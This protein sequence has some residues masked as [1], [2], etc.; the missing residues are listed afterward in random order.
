[1]RAASDAS[2]CA[3]MVRRMHGLTDPEMDALRSPLRH[4]AMNSDGLALRLHRDRST[5]C[6]SLQRPVSCQVVG[7]ERRAL[8]RGGHHHACS[9]VPREAIRGRLA[10]CIEEWYARMRAL[11]DR[12][13]EDVG[14]A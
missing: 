5:V 1:M 2:S 11:L 14:A 3:D 6:G 7:R 9:A 13:G 12:F 8:A 10:T 4:G